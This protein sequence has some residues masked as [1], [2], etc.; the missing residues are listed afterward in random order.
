[1]PLGDGLGVPDITGEGDALGVA[2]LDGVGVGVRLG[3]GLRD[4]LDDRVGLG[5]GCVG[6]GTGVGL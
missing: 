2:E 4:G 1:M 5:A 3:R 6:L